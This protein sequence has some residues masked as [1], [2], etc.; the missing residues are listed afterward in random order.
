MFVCFRRIFSRCTIICALAKLYIHTS[1]AS[2]TPFYGAPK[3]GKQK[4]GKF[5]VR[6]PLN[7][8]VP[9]GDRSVLT[10]ATIK[11]P[12]GVSTGKRKNRHTTTQRG[13]G[14]ACLNQVMANMCETGRSHARIEAQGTEDWRAA[15]SASRPLSNPPDRP[16][17]THDDKQHR[18]LAQ[19]INPSTATQ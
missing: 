19:K 13:E 4:H 14:W 1:K 16:F 11:S 15:D 10:A 9:A 17:S 7:V 3:R 12:C 5:D 6:K 2:T 8:P 18:K